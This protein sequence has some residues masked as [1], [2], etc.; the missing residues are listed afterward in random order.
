MVFWKLLVGSLHP[1]NMPY[2]NIEDKRAQQRRWVKANH[3]KK[4]E[5][6]RKSDLKQIHGMTPAEYNSYM[7]QGCAINGCSKPARAVDHDHFICDR[8]YHS[9]DKCR[10]GP[11]C[12]T[13]N[14]RTIALIDKLRAGELNSEL[15]YLGLNVSFTQ[16]M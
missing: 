9:C 4:L 2:K 7:A 11:L 13:H 8:D 5:F 3:A 1:R 10:R 12:W 16:R 6:S 14:T 15:E